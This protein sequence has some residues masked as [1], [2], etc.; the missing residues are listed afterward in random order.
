MADGR[1]STG[2]LVK[3]T[4][5]KISEHLNMLFLVFSLSRALSIG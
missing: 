2:Y 3:P 5:R 4:E 1:P